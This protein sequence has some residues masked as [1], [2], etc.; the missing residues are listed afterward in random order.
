MVTLKKEMIRNAA[1]VSYK[2][3]KLLKNNLKKL[4]KEYVKN[5]NETN[6]G[7]FLSFVFIYMTSFFYVIV[8]KRLWCVSLTCC[9]IKTDF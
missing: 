2:I 5:E 8:K 6:K 7:W 9:I 1:P 3:M 4:K